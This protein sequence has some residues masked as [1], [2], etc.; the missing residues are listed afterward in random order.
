M[1]MKVKL[2][3]SQ[4]EVANDPHRF[5]VICAGRRWG[6]SVLSRLLILKWALDNP[7]LY[8]IVSPTFQ[9]GKDIHWM[10]GF[11]S[12]LPTQLVKNWNDADL[13]VTLQNGA[14]IQLK[15]A[16]NPDRLKGV[17]L[18]GLIIDEIATMRNW[19]WIWQEALRPTLTD[20][21]A[22]AIF[23]STPKGFNHF[24]ELYTKVDPSY[25]SWKF[26]SYD[27]PYVSKDEI[28][29]AKRTLAN[30]YFQQEYMADFRKYTGLVYKDFDIETHVIKPFA[31][32]DDW[33]VYRGF[34]FGSTN[35]T[36][37]VWVAVSPDNLWVIFHNYS[38]AGKTID[39][40]AGVIAT[41]GQNVIASYGDP[42]GAQW[43]AEFNSKNIFITPAVKEVGTSNN[44]WVR[45]GIEK[46][47]EKLRIIP[48]VKPYSEI[49][50]NDKGYADL[51]VFDYCTE[52]I[53]EF[54]AY[55]WRENN[56]NVAQD[57]NEPDVPEKANDHLM[58]ALRYVAVS[59]T[60]GSHYDSEKYG[61]HYENINKENPNKWRIGI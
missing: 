55:R 13:Q 6:K 4:L 49:P 54:Q 51:Y 2:H 48:R 43:I 61:V 47:K 36:A 39:Y 30:D 60:S 53:K 58:D 57:I 32:P 8:W 7:G 10:Q 9:Q 56:P 26:T 1:Q 45:F 3:K 40:H 11:K 33:M 18:R 29:D 34:D 14:V 20:Y 46:I 16:E 22:P 37:C 25:K 42:S 27:N 23:I 28:D 35:P 5:K 21:K 31:I 38:Q 59:Y 50:N 19:N 24:Y 15:S 12:E 52:I 41:M 17:K 44:Q